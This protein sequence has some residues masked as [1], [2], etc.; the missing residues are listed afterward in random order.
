M[1]QIRRPIF[2]IFRMGIILTLISLP[3]KSIDPALKM[4]ETATEINLIKTSKY[5]KNLDGN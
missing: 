1:K 3:E 2:G 4:L 5:A